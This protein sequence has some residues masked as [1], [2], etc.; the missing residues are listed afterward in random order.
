MTEAT[1]PMNPEAITEQPAGSK[2]RVVGPARILIIDHEAAIRASLKA[3][4]RMEAFLGTMAG[5]G[6]TS[7][8]QLASSEFDLLLLDLALPGENGIDLLPRILEMQPAL[9]VIMITASDCCTL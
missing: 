9:P 5:A 1:V 2:A 4:M 7:L 6:P 3:S 8:E